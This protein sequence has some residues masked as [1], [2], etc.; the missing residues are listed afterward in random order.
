[1]SFTFATGNAYKRRVW[2]DSA[3]VLAPMAVETAQPP[4]TISFCRTLVA[5][6]AGQVDFS[7]SAVA[8]GLTDWN[9]LALDSR[10]ATVSQ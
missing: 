4:A 5:D 10:T 6:G 2:S 1:L 3:T 9:E 7:T 8:P